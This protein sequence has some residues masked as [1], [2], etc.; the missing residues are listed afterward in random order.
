MVLELA[1][2][3]WKAKGTVGETKDAKNADACLYNCK[4]QRLQMVHPT[5][6]VTGYYIGFQV[7]DT[8]VQYALCPE[9]ITL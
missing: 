7:K 1:S 2:H 6:F 4:T 8:S 5:W 9:D 3:G